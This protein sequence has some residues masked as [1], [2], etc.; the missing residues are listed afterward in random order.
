MKH[1]LRTICPHFNTN[2]MVQEYTQKLYIPSADRM[3][4]QREAKWE[5]ARALTVWKERVAAEW[6]NV[7]VK[8]VATEDGARIAVG[9]GL[10]IHAEISLGNLAPEDVAAEVYYG[11]VDSKGNIVGAKAVRMVHSEK[12]AA[13]DHQFSADIRCETSGQHGFSVRVFPHH[14]DLVHREE[15]AL[16]AWG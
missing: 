5:P 6:G 3:H 10:T 12:T 15:M 11:P 16:I 13:G 2:R 14:A 7:A 8:S 9:E 4:A 1:A